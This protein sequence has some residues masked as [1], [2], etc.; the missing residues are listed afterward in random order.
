MS[1]QMTL[2]LFKVKY[3]IKEANAEDTGI[4]EEATLCRKDVDAQVLKGH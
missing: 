3:F 4:L 1:R 2:S